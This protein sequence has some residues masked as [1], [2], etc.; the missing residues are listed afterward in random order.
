[1]NRNGLAARARWGALVAALGVT[2]LLGASPA[3]AD[4]APAPT[5]RPKI[6]VPPRSEPEDC[7]WVFGWRLREDGPPVPFLELRCA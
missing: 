2:L 7:Q 6:E 4:V 3:Q 1:M 5:P